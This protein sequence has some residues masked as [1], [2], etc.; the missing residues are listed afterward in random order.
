LT[1]YAL[2]PG[3]FFFLRGN[4]E[5]KEMNET[6]G[7]KTEILDRFG[8]DS[9]WDRIHIIFSYLPLAAIV[10]GFCICLHGGIGPDIVN[11]DTI[12]GISFPLHNYGESKI[13]SDI[14]WSD[15]SN[16]SAYFEFSVRGI[17]SLFGEYALKEWLEAIGMSMMVRAHQCVSHGV[18]VF[19]QKC[20]TVFSSSNYNKSGNCAGYLRVSERSEIEWEILEPVKF[21]NSRA[22]RFTTVEPTQKSSTQLKPRPSRGRMSSGR[23][24][25]L[26]I[27]IAHGYSLFA[28]PRRDSAPPF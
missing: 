13:V 16:N 9:L 2:Y 21:V 1:L 15:P 11:L 17:G 10:G 4:H 22:A 18:S 7:F 3:Q 24:G 12:R 23:K 28:L 26:P 25:F 6:H 27:G 5:F 19:A 8:D 14:V 20:I